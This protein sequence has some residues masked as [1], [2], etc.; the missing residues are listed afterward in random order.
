MVLIS[1]LHLCDNGWKRLFRIL[2]LQESARLQKICS[3][4]D[5]LEYYHKHD[6]ALYLDVANT[7]RLSL[8]HG[9]LWK[10]DYRI[11]ALS[12]RVGLGEKAQESPYD[13]GFLAEVCHWKSSLGSSPNGALAPKQK[14]AIDEVLKYPQFVALLRKYPDLKESFLLWTVRDQNDP[15]IFML[16]PN[17]TQKIVEG[18]LSGRVGVDNLLRLDGESLYLKCENGELDLRNPEAKAELANGFMVTFQDICK[19]FANRIN[20][21]EDLE[22]NSKGIL[23][24]SPKHFGRY[25]PK[26]KSYRQIDFEQPKWWEQLPYES[27]TTTEETQ[28]LLQT[29][30]KPDGKQWYYSIVGASECNNDVMIGGNHGYAV[31]SIPGE[32][33]NYTQ[34]SF[35]KFI[36]N[37]FPRGCDAT[38][39]VAMQSVYGRIISPDGTTKET[40]R[41]R[42]YLSVAI[43]PEEGKAIMQEIKQDI[44]QG[45]K[46][47]IVFQLFSDNC[48]HWAIE[49]IRS[50]LSPMQRSCSYVQPLEVQARG[51]LRVALFIL[52]WIPVFI[53]NRMLNCFA[54]YYGGYNEITV[55][56]RDGTE[57]RSHFMRR[58]PWDPQRFLCAN[59]SIFLLRR[60]RGEMR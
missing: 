30:A 9:D 13:F 17:I 11:Y 24:W 23:N 20:A 56:K 38:L 41:D 35:G 4:L 6:A 60:R 52:N 5:S 2:T 40:K 32:D 25:D 8:N 43:S 3:A 36:Y 18:A 49:M 47:E 14:Q 31:I 39:R 44:Q 21:F 12:R 53:R 10:L 45:F 59:P 26:I 19:S 37:D 15:K 28:F 55:K 7:A 58:S 48:M 42:E 29:K 51:V 1:H 50:K 34:Y 22:S 57:Y 16:Y 54:W 46:K 33:G 27:T